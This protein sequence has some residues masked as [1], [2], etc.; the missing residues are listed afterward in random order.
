MSKNTIEFESTRKDLTHLSGLVFFEKLIKSI[1]LDSFIGK[2]LP[3][4]KWVRRQTPKQKF[5]TILYSFIAGAEC[6][7]DIE[8]LRLDS[9]F[10]E[11]T[12]DASSAVTMGRFLRSITFKNYQKL[13]NYLP[14]LAFALREKIYPKSDTLILNMDATDHVQHGKYIEGVGWNYKDN[15]CLSSQN[16][17]D[18]YGLCYGWHLREGSAHSSVGAVEMLSQIMNNLP[19]NHGKRVYFRADSAYGN[20][21][22]YNYLLLNK[23]NFTICLSEV[24]WGS[25]LKKYESK[26]KWKKTNLYFFESNKC[27]IGSCLYPVKDL[28]N[29]GFL[30]VV[31]VRAKNEKLKPGETNYYRHYAIITDMSEKQ[32]SDEAVVKFYP[33]SEH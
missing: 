4:G 20:K 28:Y 10:T 3:S 11:I 15:W 23:V 27:Q 25:L 8:S 22:I 6:I 30:R 32:M 18:E 26:I 7:E 21:D 2:L 9:V 31:F 1:G 12:A 19:A 17:F 14:K 5:F 16:C 29:R 24:S 13:Q 33:R